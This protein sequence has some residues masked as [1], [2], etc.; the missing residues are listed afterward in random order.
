MAAILRS[1]QEVPTPTNTK[2]A[3]QRRSDAEVSTPSPLSA[4]SAAA[5]GRD[6]LTASDVLALQG[7]AGNQAAM[8]LIQ[9]KRSGTGDEGTASVHKAARMGI[10]GPAGA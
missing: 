6:T 2:L 3:Q 8:R 9:A 10:G 7:A 4:F 5:S 1:E